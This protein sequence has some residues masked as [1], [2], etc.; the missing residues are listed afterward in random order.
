MK[1]TMERSELIAAV[2]TVLKAMPSRAPSPL[3]ECILMEANLQKNELRLLCTDTSLQ[4]ET[5]TPASVELAGVIAVPGKLFGEIIRRLPE[6]PIEIE[7]KEGQEKGNALTI[8][9]GKS[10]TNLQGM[11]PE[12]FPEM[13]VAISLSEFTIEQC[14]LSSMI[15]QTLFAT[16]Q[17]DSRPILTGGYL[18]S[19]GGMLRMVGLDG[20]RLAVRNEGC[21]FQDGISA[22]VPGA[23]LS[24]IERVLGD[25]GMVKVDISHTTA[26]FD[27]GHTRINTV[28]LSGEYM[29]YQKI[30]PTE[31]L[32]CVTVNRSELLSAI[33]RASLMAREGKNNLI[34]FSIGFDTL[35]I[36]SNSEMGDVVEELPIALSGGELE[37][38]FN[39]KYLTDVLKVLDSEEVVMEFTTNVSPC[40]VRPVEGSAWLYLVLPVRIFA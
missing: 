35:T 21:A 3:L 23:S 38:A 20:Y 19:E 4:I 18:C 31:R 5:F 33:D 10:K 13:P 2:N 30:I 25:E 27:M 16:A 9:Q 15:R 39:A 7:L 24:A 26:L 34:R 28:L 40:V 29:K 1:F 6:G 22:V 12:E 14:K 8:R 37:I 36:T 32:T 17:E 11:S